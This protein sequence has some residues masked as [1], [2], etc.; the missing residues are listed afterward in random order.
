MLL[1][2]PGHAT[3]TLRGIKAVKWAPGVE[4]VAQACPRSSGISPGNRKTAR[5]CDEQ[6]PDPWEEQA[7]GGRSRRAFAG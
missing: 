3:R 2:N 5:T 6:A 7:P 1:L 4:A